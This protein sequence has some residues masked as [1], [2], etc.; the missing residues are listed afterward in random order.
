MAAIGRKLS[1]NG[2]T[3]RSTARNAPIARPSGTPSSAAIAKPANTRPTLVAMPIKLIVFV[4][5]DGWLRVSLMLLSNFT[6]G[7]P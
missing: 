7:G 2:S 3:L 4:L 1:T 5:A 6:V